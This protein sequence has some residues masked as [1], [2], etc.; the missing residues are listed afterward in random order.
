[1]SNFV[2]V[3][4]SGIEAVLAKLVQLDSVDAQRQ[5]T[6]DVGEFVRGK[7]QRYPPYKYVSRRTAY[8]KTFQSDRQRRWFFAA[9]R[10]GELQIPYV[11][12]RTLRN[13]WILADA[14]GGDMVLRNIV[15]YAGYVQKESSQS[16]MMRLRDW[17]TEERV[18]QENAAGIGR[19]ADESYNRVLRRIGA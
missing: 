2:D 16:R 13:S 3:E 18:V 5:V 1:M 8:G 12:T 7:L 15:P 10:S 11:R 9:L 6:R 17:T 4:V 14:P 19:T